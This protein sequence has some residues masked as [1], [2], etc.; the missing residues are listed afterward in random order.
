ML[1]KCWWKS[2]GGLTI[3]TYV[4]G[5][6]VWVFF[7]LP[8]YFR[9]GATRLMWFYDLPTDAATDTAS[10][11]ILPTVGRTRPLLTL[12]TPLVS[13]SQFHFPTAPLSPSLPLC[14]LSVLLSGLSALFFLS[15]SLFFFFLRLTLCVFSF[16]VWLSARWKKK[17]KSFSADQSRQIYKVIRV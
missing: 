5:N 9:S 15:L 8:I 12:S 7:Y 10:V 13:L 6:T 2:V 1:F 16:G 17:R 4:G 3:N 14:K 11:Y